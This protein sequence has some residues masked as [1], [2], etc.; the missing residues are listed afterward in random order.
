MC[1]YTQYVVGTMLQNMVS[2]EAGGMI[3]TIDRLP[4][5]QDQFYDST[6]SLLLSLVGASRGLLRGHLQHAP[7]NNRAKLM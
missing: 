4:H 2:M 6:V 7:T 5:V 3:S 1:E